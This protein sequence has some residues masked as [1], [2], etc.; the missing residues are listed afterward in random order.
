MKI[1]ADIISFILSCCVTSIILFPFLIARKPNDKIKKELLE[2]GIIHISPYTDLIVK[3]GIL[4]GT[5]GLNSYS[6]L[7]RKCVFFFCGTPKKYAKIF[8]FFGSNK[9]T[10]KGIKIIVNE[11]LLENISYR[12]FDKTIM[13]NGDINLSNVTY[14]VLEM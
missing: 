4:K 3:E 2:N 1:I 7:G 6:N 11:S 5:K 14:E 10:N 9:P 12:L 13:V 8:N